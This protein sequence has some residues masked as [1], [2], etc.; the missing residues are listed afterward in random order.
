MKPNPRVAG[1]LA[2]V[3]LIAVVAWMLTRP[4]QGNGTLLAS[5]TIEA[6]EARL[7]FQVP[8]RIDSVLVREGQSVRAG[9]V[10][11]MLDRREMSARRDQA[12][13]LLT[14]LEH[15]S[16]PEEIAQAAA[17]VE[18]ARQKFQDARRDLDR[19]HTLFAGGAVS[20]EVLDKTQMTFE[21]AQSQLTQTEEQYRLVKSGPR[22]ERIEAQRSQLAQVEAVLDN[23][24]IRAP[25][26]GVVTVRHR[27]PGETAG[28]GAPVLSVLEPSS[29]W[30]RIYVREDRVA[31]VR[32]GMPATITT[33]TYRD[34]TY[35]GEVVFVASQAEFTPKNVQTTE[36][37]VKL[38]YA[39]KVQIAGDD[40]FDLKPGMPADV[41]LALEKR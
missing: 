18:G 32:L 23:M 33:D 1:L 36:E 22:R 34:R 21:V 38:V 27:E 14:E 20:Q 13:A 2:A 7:G 16:R 30:V 11:A 4:R 29:R 40:A 35:P 8:G 41:R 24:T 17:A 5:G 6:T 28:A 12:Q 10:L 15:G 3:L 37:R 39:V 25:S 31:A 9:Q 26:D 19:A